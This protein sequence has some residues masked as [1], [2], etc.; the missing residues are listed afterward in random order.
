MRHSGALRLTPELM[1]GAFIPSAEHAAQS[2]VP[3]TH[4]FKISK[5][6]PSLILLLFFSRLSAL[7]V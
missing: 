2:H 7:Y 1:R 5:E 6:N 4:E 3:S